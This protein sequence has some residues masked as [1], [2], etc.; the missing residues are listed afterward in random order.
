VTASRS[1]AS[2]KSRRRS[3]DD[4]RSPAPLDPEL[5]PHR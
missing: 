5:T 2:V 4:E 3:L 1:A